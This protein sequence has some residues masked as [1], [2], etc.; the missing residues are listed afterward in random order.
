M[1]DTL[2]PE[3]ERLIANFARVVEQRDRFCELLSQ[4]ESAMAD[5][6]DCGRCG[7]CKLAKNIREAIADSM[8]CEVLS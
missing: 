5:I 7:G 2:S 1:S 8:N 4:A 3:H 6:C